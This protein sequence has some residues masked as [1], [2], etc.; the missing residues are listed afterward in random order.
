MSGIT[1][2][3]SRFYKGT[4]QLQTYGSGV[5]QKD[6]LLVDME[7]ANKDRTLATHAQ[8]IRC[9]ESKDK[10]AYR[11]LLWQHMGYFE[12]DIEVL[13]EKRPELFNE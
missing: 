6:T 4:Q 13:R 3:Y 8:F 2:D 5:E 12:K 10:E 9:V 11:K 7:N 1:T